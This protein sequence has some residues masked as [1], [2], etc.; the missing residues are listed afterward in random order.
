MNAYNRADFEFPVAIRASLP[1]ATTCL[2]RPYLLGPL[3]GRYIYRF[4][5]RILTEIY[6]FQNLTYFVTGDVINDVMNIF[7]CNCSHNL[8][9]HMHRKCNDDVFARCL[10]IMKN[11]VISFIKEY[12]G[13]TLRPPCDV[14]DDVIIIKIPFLA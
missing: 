11:V 3:G 12:R 2:E 10:I 5:C 14:I 13:P 8:M 7:L 9:I 6:Q 1:S 4:Y